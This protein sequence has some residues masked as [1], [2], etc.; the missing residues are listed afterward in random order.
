MDW[1]ERLALKMRELGW[2][3][4]EL[5]RRSGVPYDSIK[6]YLDGAVAQPRGDIM[7]KLA[8]AVG[9]T[10]LWLQHGL[11]V[12]HDSTDTNLGVQRL[13]IV[14]LGE[15]AAVGLSQALTTALASGRTVPAINHMG[16]RVYAVL[17]EDDSNAPVLRPGDYV[18]CDPD[19][20]PIPGKFVVASVGTQAL[21]RRYRETTVGASGKPTIELCPENPNFPTVGGKAKVVILGR[22][23]H[24]VRAL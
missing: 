12:R 16:P 3:M 11:D 20:P 4:R 7:G 24:H 14:R 19:A 21:L 15:V 18:L 1:N 13:P 10:T 22:V 5:H 6:K 23:T 17:I 9:V 8:S 2:S